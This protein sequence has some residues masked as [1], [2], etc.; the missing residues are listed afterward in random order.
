MGHEIEAIALKRGHEIVGVFD[1]ESDWMHNT[2]PSCDI[3]ID[4]STPDSANKVVSKCLD[5]NVP[6][7]SG[8]TGWNILV[9]EAKQRAINEH[10]AFFYASNYSLG[11]NIFSII[12]NRLASLLCNFDEY[13]AVL[14][15]THHIRKK[16][17]PSG[18]AISLAEGII[19]NCNRYNGWMLKD[20]LNNCQNSK[21][22][23]KI[24]IQSERTGEVPGT[25]SIRWCS[26]NDDIEIIHTAHNRKGFA[27]G[28]VIAAE[29]ML[30]KKGYY[31]MT[32][33]MNDLGV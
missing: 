22:N 24:H 15:E 11:V 33:L 26:E 32:D 21:S 18:T 16:D 27:L 1:N 6:V 9:A 12:N 31:T 19:N 4:F 10:K 7:L 28:A 3:V 29:W 20:N 23:D 8:T 5:E 17:A 30:N 2:I 13:N 25:H 14:K